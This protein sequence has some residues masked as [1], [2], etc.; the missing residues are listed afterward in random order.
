M[1]RGVEKGV[2]TNR[3]W[4]QEHM[5]METEGVQRRKRGR[6]EGQRAVV[7]LCDVYV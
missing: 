3:K 1:G 2:E 7:I 5:E 6:K 4:E